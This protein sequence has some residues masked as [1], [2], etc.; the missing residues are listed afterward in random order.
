MSRRHRRFGAHRQCPKSTRTR[1]PVRHIGK[2]HRLEG[3][4]LGRDRHSCEPPGQSNVAGCTLWPSIPAK[5]AMQTKFII[6]MAAIAPQNDS[7]CSLVGATAHIS[8]H[9]AADKNA[10]RSNR[11]RNRY[12]VVDAVDRETELVT[13]H[14]KGHVS[15]TNTTNPAANKHSVPFLLSSADCDLLN[16]QFR[17]SRTEIAMTPAM[18]ASHPPAPENRYNAKALRGRPAP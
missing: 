7:D 1:A 15:S 16:V 12:P 8:N 14:S 3:C 9:C 5:L 2:N 4:C 17:Y 18:I 6:H 13:Q 11:G 10:C